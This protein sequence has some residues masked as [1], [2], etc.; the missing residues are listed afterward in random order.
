MRGAAAVVER[1]DEVAIEGEVVD[2]GE[3]RQQDEA[4]D[5]GVRRG[6]V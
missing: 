5:D 2:R 3:E 4:G 6:L 1:G